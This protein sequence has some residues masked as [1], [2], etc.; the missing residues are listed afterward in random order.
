MITQSRPGPGLTRRIQP[1]G[2]R[3]SRVGRMKAPASALW[4]RVLGYGGAILLMLGAVAVLALQWRSG[5]STVNA[6]TTTGS[7]GATSSSPGQT[8]PS[9]DGT[10]TMQATT[11]D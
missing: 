11:S 4:I 10:P 6:G 9:A 1:C 8:L 5:T 3:A 2:A 7:P